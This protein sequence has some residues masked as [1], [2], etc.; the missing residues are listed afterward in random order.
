MPVKTRDLNDF[1]VATPPFIETITYAVRYDEQIDDA[2]RHVQS[3]E[4]GDHE[5]A[6]PELRRTERIPPRPDAFHY[7]LAPLEGLHADE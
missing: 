5:E 1:V 4:A 7:Q 3:V 2:C 6:G